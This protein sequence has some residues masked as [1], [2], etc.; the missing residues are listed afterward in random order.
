MSI[1]ENAK[2]DDDKVPS[3]K[4]FSSDTKKTTHDVYLSTSFEAPEDYLTLFNML[5]HASENE[6][7]NFYLNSYG[8]RLDSGVQFINKL[9]ATKAHTK[10]IVESSSYS[11]GAIFPFACK[12]TE[13]REH[14]TLMWHN[15][16]TGQSRSKGN[17]IML[18]V[19]ST[20]A[21]FKKLL[22]DVCGSILTQQEIDNIVEGKDLY[23]TREQIA[24]RML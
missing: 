14:T 5:E 7:F 4:I 2:K 19:A 23:L 8:G 15:F 16:S 18:S 17:E 10:C 20:S 1:I 9:R 22:E 21:M 3:Y 12:E 11:M 24:V 13:M 6:T